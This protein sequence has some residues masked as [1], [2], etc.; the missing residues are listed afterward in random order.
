MKIIFIDLLKIYLKDTTIIED[1]SCNRES[2]IDYL[3]NSCSPDKI[4]N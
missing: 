2:I 3:V 4:K 1:L